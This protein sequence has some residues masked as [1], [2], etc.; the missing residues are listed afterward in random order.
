MS[1]RKRMVKVRKKRI[2]SMGEQIDKHKELIATQRGRKDTTQGYWK[3]EIEDKF[4]KKIEE[5][6]SYLEE[7]K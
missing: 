6:E 4:E 1:D 3:K 7:N 2:K 5:D